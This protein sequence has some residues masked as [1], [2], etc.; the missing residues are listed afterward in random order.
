MEN[1]YIKVFL[2][3]CAGISLICGF[4]NP[5]MF[6]SFGL[7]IM[8]LM[9]MK[10]F[11]EAW[12]ERFGEL[13]KNMGEMLGR[14]NTDLERAKSQWD[15]QRLRLDGCQNHCEDLAEKIS[16]FEKDFEKLEPEKIKESIKTL[17]ESNNT[18]VMKTMN[19]GPGFGG[20]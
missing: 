15:V 14:F 20:M 11:D 2:V 8:A 6:I 18:L 7:S 4:F 1:K 12:T 3:V 19:I 10:E 5:Y 16:K 17:I 9:N 13:N